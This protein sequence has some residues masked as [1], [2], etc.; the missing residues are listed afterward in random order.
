M[1]CSYIA[2]ILYCFV[3]HIAIFCD[4]CLANFLSGP[5]RSRCTLL[6]GSSGVGKGLRG[7]LFVAALG[8]AGTAHG[9][10]CD[11]GRPLV[12][13]ATSRR[14]SAKNTF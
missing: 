5:K 12:L 3:L 9:N 2:N 8:E 4:L 10:E 11:A 13:W 1:Y 14:Q 6:F 7:A